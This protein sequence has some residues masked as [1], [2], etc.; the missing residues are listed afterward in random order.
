MTNGNRYTPGLE[1]LKE[2]NKEKQKKAQDR[3]R[4]NP[5][6]CLECGNKIPYE[7]RIHG[8]FCSQSC[9]ARYS[10]RRR[11]SAKRGI[12]CLHCGKTLV[13]TKNHKFCNKSCFFE[14][15]YQEW[16]RKWLANDV[17]VFEDQERLPNQI[18][19]WMHEKYD[20]KCQL[21]GWGEINKT[22]GLVP[23]QIHHLD[24]DSRNNK[25]ENLNLLCPNC[26][27][28]TPSFGSLNNG[29]GRRNRYKARV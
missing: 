6:Y 28:L 19:R 10:N 3:Y 12:V 18:R 16:I 21:C 25:P 22:T 23:L 8:K 5:K 7:K 11:H 14:Y 9:S 17:A 20:G 15:Q 4:A 29:N 2:Y 13:G 24:G 27:S 26:H 1:K